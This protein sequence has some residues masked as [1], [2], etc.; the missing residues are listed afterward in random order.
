MIFGWGEDYIIL[1]GNLKF[2]YFVWPY[3]LVDHA[4]YGAVYL[5]LSKAVV[6]FY[7]ALRI[8]AFLPAAVSRLRYK[9]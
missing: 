2:Q 9:R 4:Y 6:S 3:P 1:P 5:Q 7:T 8:Q